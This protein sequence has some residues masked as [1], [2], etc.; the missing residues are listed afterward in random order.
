MGEEDKNTR[1]GARKRT[2]EGLCKGRAA[3]TGQLKIHKTGEIT[4]P[5][6]GAE[7]LCRK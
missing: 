3:K 5:R 6:Y 7:D 1:K 2:E 4:E